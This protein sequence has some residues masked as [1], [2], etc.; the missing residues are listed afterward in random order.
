M[1]KNAKKNAKK[2][3]KQKSER[4]AGTRLIEIAKSV[5]EDADEALKMANNLVEL[6]IQGLDADQNLYCSGCLNDP[7]STSHAELRKNCCAA[8][9]LIA[10]MFLKYREEQAAKRAADDRRDQEERAKQ[11]AVCN[12][13][14]MCKRN[15]CYE[16]VFP[17]PCCRKAYCANCHYV[18]C[19]DC[20]KQ[21]CCPDCTEHRELGDCKVCELRAHDTYKSFC[22]KCRKD[23][24][25]GLCCKHTIVK[26]DLTCSECESREN[27][28][29]IRK[30]GGKRAITTKCG[31]KLTAK[32]RKLLRGREAPP[33]KNQ[34]SASIMEEERSK[35]SVRGVLVPNNCPD[36]GTEKCKG[37][38]GFAHPDG[39]QPDG[40]CPGHET[41]ETCE[42]SDDDVERDTETRDVAA[43]SDDEE[44]AATIET[45]SALTP[46]QIA[47]MAAAGISESTPIPSASTDAGGEEPEPERVVAS[48]EDP[49]EAEEEK[50]QD[51][52]SATTSSTVD[53][54]E[55]AAATAEGK[56]EPRVN[57]S[58]GRA[59]SAFERKRRHA[60]FLKRAKEL[61]PLP[62]GNGKFSGM[63]YKQFEESQHQE[64]LQRQMMAQMLQG[65]KM[66]KPDDDD[67]DS[68]EEPSAAAGETVAYD[69]KLHEHSQAGGCCGGH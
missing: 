58:G 32:Q 9:C 13:C 18:D 60:D 12:Q 55:P 30:G 68:D 24:N 25:A 15:G 27:N 62:K 11:E 17:C 69:E 8:S 6:G 54:A 59:I 23:F 36:C 19:G 51:E 39:C 44:N 33:A 3:Q 43:D 53:G 21:V 38:T 31:L 46:N 67:E 37:H 4:G 64:M 45:A 63:S 48:Q 61:P 35:S 28:M 29:R 1:S 49:D 42:G 47:L 14:N 5:I 22:R 2:R 41:A 65:G 26:L 16:C 20:N 40:S 56:P 50:K 7:S 34:P 10:E 52:P 57:A 66:P